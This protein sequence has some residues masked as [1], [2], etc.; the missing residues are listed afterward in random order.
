MDSTSANPTSAEKRDSA[1]S[2]DN[3]LAKTTSIKQRDSAM[4]V[5]SFKMTRFGAGL[6]KLAV[7]FS[8]NGIMECEPQLQPKT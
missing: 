2:V 8:W 6:L 7:L 1:M 5:T 4:S 3:L